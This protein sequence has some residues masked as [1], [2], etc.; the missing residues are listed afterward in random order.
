MRPSNSV[1]FTVLLLIPFFASA[2]DS[3]LVFT[4]SLQAAAVD[5]D[6]PLW[7]QANQYGRIPSTGSFISGQW[8]LYVLYGPTSPERDRIPFFDWRG[9]L[10]L[11]TNI[12][13]SKPTTDVFFTDLFLTLKAGPFE[14]TAGQREEFMGL[15]DSTLTSGGLAMSGNARPYPKLQLSIP[16]YY[17]F[18]F[19]DD[20]IG[21]KGSYSDGMLGGGPISYGRISYLPNI[22]MHQKSFYARLGKPWQQINVYAGFN[23]QAIWGGERKIFSGG[24]SAA[25]AYRYVV[26]GKSWAFS[27]VG[28][29]FGTIDF[30]IELKTNRWEIFAYR[31]NIYEDG[32]LA[33]LRNISDGLNGIRFKRRK[34]GYRERGFFFNKFVLELLLTK[35]QGGDEF[36]FATGVFGRDNYYNHYIYSQ[37]WSYRSR[38]L[39]TPLIA[40]QGF[41]N[42]NI[43][44]QPSTFTSNNRLTAVHL[45][46]DASLNSLN[47]KLM[48]TYSHNIGTYS[49]PFSSAIV[50]YSFLLHLDKKLGRNHLG[51]ILSKDFGKLYKENSAISVAWRRYLRLDR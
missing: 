29:H 32:S 22:Y 40:P 28:N 48:S 38:S 1:F 4:G 33:Q 36:D 15:S 21:I 12:S 16:E 6:V 45:G 2:Q 50:E 20:L 26:L 37:G 25:E 30:G 31:Q 46:I 35:N 17:N 49:A 47:F 51:I 42:E 39:G 14:L 18:S 3:T 44:Y 11:T 23:H 19:L 8:G 9:G 27:R 5:N 34:N 13:M 7:L 24:Q 41:M 10:K 43:A